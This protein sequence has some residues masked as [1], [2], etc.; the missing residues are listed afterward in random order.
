ME[1]Y[2]KLFDWQKQNGFTDSEL[3]EFLGV[4]FSLI[5]HIR[6]GRRAAS[7]KLSRKIASIT[8]N[9]IT[10]MEMLYPE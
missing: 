3:A 10:A 5:S 7:K 6:A 4:H 1:K 2:K 9:E 8:N